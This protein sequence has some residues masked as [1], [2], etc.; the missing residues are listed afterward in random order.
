MT[1]NDF[2]A[3]EKNYDCTTGQGVL[4]AATDAAATDAAAT[5]AATTAAAATAAATTA[6]A[7]PVIPSIVCDSTTNAAAVKTI[8][9]K[10]LAAQPSIVRKVR[11]ANT[12]CI[13]DNSTS[14]HGELHCE[15]ADAPT[16]GEWHPEI[17]S[18]HGLIP[19]D[20][21][22]T[23]IKVDCTVT[24]IT[25]KTDLNVLGGDNLTISGTNFPKFV[26][27]NTVEIGFSNSGSTKCVLQSSKSTEMICLTKSFDK[28]SNLDEEFTMIININE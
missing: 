2:R 28:V 3:L 25:P 26:A 9:G 7:E 24:A 6:A 17:Y 20:L 14:T 23:K 5:A 21:A 15:L 27:D 11:F 10:A 12:D 8:T 18:D 16:C 19:T 4:P 13:F 1:T 22:A